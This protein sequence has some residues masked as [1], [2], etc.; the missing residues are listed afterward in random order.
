VSVSP[1][2]EVMQGQRVILNCTLLGKVDHYVLEWF[3]V[4]ALG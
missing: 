2:V 3:L 4:S 1:L